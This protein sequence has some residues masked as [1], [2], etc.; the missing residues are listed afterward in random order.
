MTVTFA[1]ATGAPVPLGAGTAGVWTRAQALARQL[2]RHPAEL[3]DINIFH[4]DADDQAM[5]QTGTKGRR[6]GAALLE[7]AKAGR[8]WIQMRRIQ[9]HWPELG[10]AMRQIFIPRIGGPEVFQAVTDFTRSLDHGG[11]FYIGTR[12]EIKDQTPRHVGLASGG[13]G[14]FRA[15][16]DA[17]RGNRTACA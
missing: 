11:E 7:A 16:T 6:G 13:Q 17:A 3:F 5:L 10:A 12:V 9:D 8:M 2:E 15:G 14:S 4:Y 1:P